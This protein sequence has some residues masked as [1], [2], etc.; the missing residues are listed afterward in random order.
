MTVAEGVLAV[1]AEIGQVVAGG[2]ATKVVGNDMS[3]LVTVGGCLIR[4]IEEIQIPAPERG[5]AGE[6]IGEVGGY[7]TDPASFGTTMVSP[8]RY[9]VESDVSPPWVIDEGVN[10]GEE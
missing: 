9:A 10:D 3:M 2:S 7:S 1:R 8:P 4:G 5:E 6:A